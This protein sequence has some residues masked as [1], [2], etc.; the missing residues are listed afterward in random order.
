MPK[1]NVY[2]NLM[3]IQMLD[4]FSLKHS[5]QTLLVLLVYVL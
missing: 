5:K 4:Q 2:P 1:L 3:P